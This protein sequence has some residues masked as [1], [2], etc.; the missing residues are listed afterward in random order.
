[1][2]PRHV[3]IWSAST[4]LANRK[5]GSGLRSNALYDG[6]LVWNKVTMRNAPKTGKHVWRN[7]P[8]ASRGSR[9]AVGDRRR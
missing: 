2:C 7:N 3:E 9:A 6:R 4:I 1:V 5:P 8:Q